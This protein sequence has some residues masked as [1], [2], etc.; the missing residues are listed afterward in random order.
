MMFTLFAGC[1]GEDEC[2]PGEGECPNICDSG[3]GILA[4]S[5]SSDS[6]C[7][8]G[9]ACIESACT[10]YT[11]ANEGC[12][13]AGGTVPNW[14]PDVTSTD[15]PEPPGNSFYKFT[16]TLP[17]GDELIFE[18]DLTGDDTIFSFGSTHIAPAISFAMTDTIYNPTFAIITFN[19]GIVQGSS[20]YPV[21]C[22]GAGNYE[23]TSGPPEITFFI[24]NNT[25]TSTQSLKTGSITVDQW[26]KVEGGIFS[27]SVTG[28]IF[29]DTTADIKEELL[30]EGT[31]SFTLPE[32][33]GVNQ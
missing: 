12:S 4:E 17:H 3:I 14:T 11:G 27:G 15:V 32:P 16:V 1:G 7:N 28:K 23:F 10:P 18:R 22:P 30:V 2:T 6:D 24:D 8:C 29:E 21:Q 26:S 31:F 5:C 25:Y 9:L 19:F 33:A 13:C 20:T